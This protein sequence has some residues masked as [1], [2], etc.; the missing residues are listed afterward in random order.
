MNRY[1]KTFVSCVAQQSS[2]VTLGLLV[3]NIVI[4]QVSC[5][6][7]H[8]ANVALDGATCCSWSVFGRC[9]VGDASASVGVVSHCVVAVGVG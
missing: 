5:E 7:L 3:P 9:C 8:L 2:R 6:Q 1:G 4:N